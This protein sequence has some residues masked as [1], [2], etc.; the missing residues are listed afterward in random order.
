MYKY[1][2]VGQPFLNLRFSGPR[3]AQG[4]GRRK[5]GAICGRAGPR[6]RAPVADVCTT[7]QLVN[8]YIHEYKHTCVYIYIEI[9]RDMHIYIYIYL[10]TC[11]HVYTYLYM[12]CISFSV[13][14]GFCAL[15]VGSCRHVGGSGLHT[16][17]LYTL[18]WDCG[19][20]HAGGGRGATFRSRFNAGAGF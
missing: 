14:W 13:A 19:R 5:F 3:A 10:H 11:V 1:A 18:P 12:V 2:H 7:L 8:T 6:P 9:G 15:P 4:P 20:S 16:G 17:L